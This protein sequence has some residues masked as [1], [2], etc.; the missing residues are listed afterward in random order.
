MGRPLIQRS[1][2]CVIALLLTLAALAAAFSAPSAQGL[3]ALGPEGRVYAVETADG[4]YTALF[5]RNGRYHDSRPRTG[6]WSF[7]GRTLCVLVSRAGPRAPEYEVCLPWRDLSIGESYL[8][9]NW[10][11]DGDLARVTRVE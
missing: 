6:Y 9:E 3:Q 7:D 4:R 10:T 5:R 1:V 2:G 11:P 8:S